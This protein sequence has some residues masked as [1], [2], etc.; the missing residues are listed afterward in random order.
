MSAE[1]KYQASLGDLHASLRATGI[2]FDG[3][4]PRP[5]NRN[6]VAHFTEN[7][8][9]YFVQIN[10]AEGTDQQQREQLAAVLAAHVFTKRKPKAKA[11]IRQALLGLT[12]A[13][14]N[15]VLLEIAVE[16][17]F[18]DPSFAR[19]LGLNLDGDELDQTAGAHKN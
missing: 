12:Q 2:A 10:F 8:I 3:L 17:I 14:R 5:P 9:P 7:G 18:S 19:R 11:D 16:V 15:T 13:Q 1:S 6:E 4:T